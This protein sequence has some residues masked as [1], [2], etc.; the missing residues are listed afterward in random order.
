MLGNLT[1]E[2]FFRI[3]TSRELTSRDMVQRKRM[4]LG[5]RSSGQ[6]GQSLISLCTTGYADNVLAL[7][8]AA[9]FYATIPRRLRPVRQSFMLATLLV[10][11][12]LSLRD[13]CSGMI[14]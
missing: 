6:D 8:C 3:L 5:V 10:G 12:S 1:V 13:A 11:I 9:S 7:D 4:Q 2:E 14:V